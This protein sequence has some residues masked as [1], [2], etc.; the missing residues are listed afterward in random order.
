MR[1]ACASHRAGGRVV[2]FRATP[3]GNQYPLHHHNPDAAL[4]QD[5]PSHYQQTGSHAQEV[6]TELHYLASSEG[7]VT[8]ASR[9]SLPTCLDPAAEPQDPA[10]RSLLS[11]QGNLA[12]RDSSATP[13]V[14]PKHVTSGS[15]A[16]NMRKGNDEH[17]G[18]SKHVRFWTSKS[19][20]SLQVASQFSSALL[21]GKNP[22]V[23]I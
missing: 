10:Y 20:C 11:S 1:R 8:L 21:T 12:N 9:T 7:L 2:P 13:E 19:E 22:D 23:Y 16:R 14:T 3:Q 17:R 18:G 15:G 6:G 5:S 4:L